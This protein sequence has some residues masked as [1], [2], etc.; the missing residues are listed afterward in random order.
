MRYQKAH[1]TKEY[2]SVPS[3]SSIVSFIL[4]CSTKMTDWVY[5]YSVKVYTINYTNKY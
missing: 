5:L 2:N 4:K 1:E 3:N